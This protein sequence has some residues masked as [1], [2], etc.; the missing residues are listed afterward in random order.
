MFIVTAG[1]RVGNGKVLVEWVNRSE[2]FL[3]TLPSGL[4]TNCVPAST[5]SSDL[6]K[7]HMTAHG[8]A[9]SPVYSGDLLVTA[10]GNGCYFAP[11]PGEHWAVSSFASSGESSGKKVS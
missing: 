4:L 2:P 6:S 11:L 9:R 7:V 3:L 1:H 5:H 10:A 8:R